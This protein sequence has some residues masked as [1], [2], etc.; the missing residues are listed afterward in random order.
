MQN[1]K[2]QG[3]TFTL[4]VPTNWFVASTP[5]F[6][7]MFVVPP[8]SEEIK[9]NLAVTI[10][11]LKEEVNMTEI[12]NS[13]KFAQEKAYKGYEVIS[14]VTHQNGLEGF[15]R[16]FKWF[17]PDGEVNIIQRQLFVLFN[18]VIYTIT[19]TREDK[20]ETESIEPIFTEVMAS[21]RLDKNA[22]FFLENASA[23]LS[24]A[25]NPKTQEN[26]L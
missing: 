15:E 8:G 1:M 14:E 9:A 23:S 10:I 22:K 16:K 13:S 26:G 18:Q 2:F 4:Q 20:A 5:K 21:F 7:A 25:G 17:N 11:P 24:L 19:A 12:L 3:P 6:Q